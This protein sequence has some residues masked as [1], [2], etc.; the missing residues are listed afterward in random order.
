MESFICVE[1]AKGAYS[2]ADEVGGKGASLLRLVNA[3]YPVPYGF[4]IPVNYFF[5]VLKKN[6]I[7]EKIVS[8]CENTTLD[9][10]QE[11]GIILQK[12]I[13]QCDFYITNECLPQKLSDRV[14][15][16]S[17]AVSEDG[18][19]HSFAGLHDSFLNVEKNEINKYVKEV[20]ASLFTGRSMVYRLHNN[21]PL[22]EGMAVVI[23]NMINAKCAGVVF[24][25]HPVDQTYILIE[26]ASGLGNKVVDGIVTPDRYLFD[27]HSLELV[28]F[29][30]SNEPLLDDRVLQF[31]IINS[32]E[33]ERQNGKPQDIEWVYDDKLYFMQ[34]R[35]VLFSTMDNKVIE[36]E[37]RYIWKRYVSRRSPLLW[38][39]FTDSSTTRENWLKYTGEDIFVSFKSYEY[40]KWADAED[41]K[42]IMLYF[43]SRVENDIRFNDGFCDRGRDKC[44]KACNDLLSFCIDNGKHN[45]T[46]LSITEIANIFQGYSERNLA[47]ATFRPYGTSM[48]D[49]ITELLA[50]EVLKLGINFHYEYVVTHTDLAF[51]AMHKNELIIG[52]K[53]ER[54]ELNFDDEIIKSLIED[55]LE[56]YAWLATY[57]YIG[58]GWT[59][60]DVVNNIK[61]HLGYCQKG[62]DDLI[63]ENEERITKLNEIKAINP[64]IR[65]ILRIA[66]DWAYLRTYRMD[67]AMEGDYRLRP[68]FLEIGRRLGLVYNDLIYLTHKEI[69][70]KLQGDNADFSIKIKRRKEY[71]S[72][73]V[74][75]DNE[76]YVFEGLENKCD[77]DE[78]EVCSSDSIVG[79]VAMK[80]R[81]K[82]TVKVI[83]SAQELGKIHE[84]DIIVT[85]MT[86]IDMAIILQ[87]CSGIITEYGGI[88]CH[89]AQLSREFNIPCIIGTKTATKIL[90][91]GDVV[92]IIAEGAQGIVEII[93]K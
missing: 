47:Q 22:L 85:P 28:S 74:V 25:K 31:L 6:N 63:L 43:K 77:T 13:K 29:E 69:L 23:Q 67:T 91:D 15:V 41:L 46:Q 51:T 4:I 38:H 32:M 19:N 58:D 72:T 62:I 75:N 27:R 93:T 60:D 17:S 80:G 92:E 83:K 30:I 71:F 1:L 35:A 8:V 89:A 64:T 12:L 81:I 59:E 73:Y 42:R 40:G 88:A 54:E 52:A 34:S 78:I 79:T 39:S 48:D 66:Q 87:K 57:R 53:M 37:K 3:E 18:D 20:W 36:I 68:M 26:I 86:T 44:I 45:Y 9:N 21:L 2:K 10:F 65:N 90:K 61:K 55:H 50:N 14:S 33:I 24:T 7:H 76:I 84:G 16:R 82:S 11:N 49:T 5:Y 70:A 56:K